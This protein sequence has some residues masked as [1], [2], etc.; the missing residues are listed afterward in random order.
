MGPGAVAMLVKGLDKVWDKLLAVTKQDDI[1]EVGEWFWIC[2]EN[3]AA[4]KDDGVMVVAVGGADGNVE[5]SQVGED[6]FVIEFPGEGKA[7]YV[8]L[9]G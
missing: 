5:E 8:S 3:W 9:A 1:E 2:G 6:A 7:E 4:T